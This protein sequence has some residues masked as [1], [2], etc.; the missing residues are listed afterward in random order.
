MCLTLQNVDDESRGELQPLATNVSHLISQTLFSYTNSCA[1]STLSSDENDF[2]DRVL[3]YESPF[4]N[5]DRMRF[6]RIGD[7]TAGG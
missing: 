1:A 3:S 4:C 7:L 5:F 6:E 2:E